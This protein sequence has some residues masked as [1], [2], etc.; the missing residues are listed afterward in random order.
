MNVE[1]FG[2]I[3]ITQARNLVLLGLG[4][5]PCVNSPA[6][7]VSRQEIQ[8]VEVN[9]T[10]SLTLTH[11]RCTEKCA[12]CQPLATR[13]RRAGSTPGDLRLLSR[14]GCMIIETDL[15]RM[16]MF[17]GLDQLLPGKA[18]GENVTNTQSH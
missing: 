3:D 7:F 18:V 9:A 1:N 12:D 16:M 17:Q 2:S 5:R 15:G 14:G 8:P 11:R 4:A 13:L 10:R 6:S